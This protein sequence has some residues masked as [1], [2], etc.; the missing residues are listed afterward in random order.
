MGRILS[1]VLGL[2]VIAFVAYKVVYGRS[3][4]GDTGGD[5]TPTQALQGAKGAAKRIEDESA[6]KAKETLN[7]QE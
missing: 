6:A 5:Q 3:L 4:S 7:T 1:L 2:L